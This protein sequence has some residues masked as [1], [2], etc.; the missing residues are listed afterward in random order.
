M[1]IA[2]KICSTRTL[3][4][5]MASFS[6]APATE[7][8]FLACEA[9]YTVENQA[10]ENFEAAHSSS[11]EEEAILS[12]ATYDQ[13]CAR[14]SNNGATCTDDVRQVDQHE[15]EQVNTMV[16][17]SCG[18]KL[19]EKGT[20]CSTQFTRE[21]IV[22]QREQCLT[23]DKELL[24]MLVLGQF[25]A[26]TTD[27]ST[28][29]TSRQKYVVFYFKGK[30]ICRKFFMFIHTLSQKKYRNLFEHYASCGTLPREHGNLHK[31]PHNRVPFDDVKDVISFVE[32]YAEVHAMPLPGRL[33]NYKSDKTLLLPSNTSKSEIY[34]Q[35][36][37]AKQA[38]GKAHVSWAK[39]HTLW[40]DTLPHIDTMKPASDLCFECQTNVRVIQESANLTEE[41]KFK[42][43]EAAEAHLKAAKGQRDYYNEQCR[44][45]KHE[46]E[47]HTPM[48]SSHYKG[49]MH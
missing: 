43:I 13:S 21:T 16:N 26:H 17:R 23:L 5:A 7:E 49:M 24:D 46:H 14:G 48:T 15:Y 39:F 29:D 25:Q 30:R 36:V 40:R 20:A 45:A 9:D 3:A 42:R 27:T 8:E 33:P 19:G 1:Q 31:A 12:P 37:T 22:T 2:L 28:E 4:F 47:A 6:F 41:E 34:R 10:T 18:C 11:E 44:Q 32:R 35:Y 38:E